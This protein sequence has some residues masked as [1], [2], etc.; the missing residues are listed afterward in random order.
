MALGPG[1]KVQILFVCTGNICRSPMAEALLRQRIESAGIPRVQVVSAGTHAVEGHPAS[2]N[3]VIIAQ[4]FG[5]DLTLHSSQPLTPWLIAHSDLILVMEKQH[6]DLIRSAEPTAAPRTFLLKEFALPPGHNPG[7]SEIAD[8]ISGDE[9]LYL[10]VFTEL[11]REIDRILPSLT[12][13]IRSAG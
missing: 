13:V 7:S 3:A 10:R 12:R 4:Q 6:R 11:D 8:P 9:D 5:V 1:R 2:Y